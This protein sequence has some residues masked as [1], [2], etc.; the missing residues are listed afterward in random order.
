MAVL[1]KVAA[2][3]VAVPNS[4]KKTNSINYLI[5]IIL[6]IAIAIMSIL[7]VKKFFES[8]RIDPADA[9][10]R[11]LTE[12][13]NKNPD[14][15]DA[16]LKLA[17]TYQLQEK[18]DEA[19]SVYEDV[20]KVDA[21]NQG[22]LYNLAVIAFNNKDYAEAEKGFKKVIKLYPGHLLALAA[23]SNLYLDQK[24]PDLA[25]Q[26]IDKAIKMRADVVDFHITKGKAYEQKGDK[27]KAKMEYKAA[28]K[29]VPDNPEAL[30]AL[31]RLEK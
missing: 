20:L 7:T 26:T 29:Y 30:K 31:S 18:W 5:I 24:K 15:L 14:N 16:R 1:P 13:V 8:Q 11:Q 25:I 19:R 23:L 3:K 6:L 4:E 22:A 17:Y 10:I 12:I 27:N 28:L 9:D 2:P 21:T